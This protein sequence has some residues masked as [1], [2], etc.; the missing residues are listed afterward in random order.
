M[1][2]AMSPAASRSAAL[3]KLRVGEPAGARHDAYFFPIK[4]DAPVQAPNRR[5]GD[6]HEFSLI[7]IKN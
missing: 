6:L 2:S 1:P 7:E 5:Q 3:A 4:I